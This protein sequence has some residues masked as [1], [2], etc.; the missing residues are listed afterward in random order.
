MNILQMVSYDRDQRN[1][2]D[3][4]DFQVPKAKYNGKNT[5]DLSLDTALDTLYLYN[6]RKVYYLFDLLSENRTNVASHTVGFFML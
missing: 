6:L 2:Q 1:F 4:Q 5:D 3:F